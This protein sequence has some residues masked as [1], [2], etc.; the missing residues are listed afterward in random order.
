MIAVVIDTNILVSAFWKSDGNPATVV[1]LML[2][3]KITPCFD[4]R[5]IEEYREV[6]ARPKLRFDKQRVNWLIGKII[7]A[8]IQVVATPSEFFMTDETDRKFFDVA[9]Y[10]NAYLITGNGKHYPQDE[11]IITPASFL[12][13][14]STFR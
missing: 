6:L 1:S 3:G 13:M 11:K 5:I 4:L 12:L 10:C 14:Y 7:S 8:G 9:K 2:Q